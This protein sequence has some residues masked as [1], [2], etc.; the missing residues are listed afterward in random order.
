MHMSA[1]WG[2]TSK[3]WEQLYLKYHWQSNVGASK[4]VNT[5]LE[6]NGNGKWFSK[7]GTQVGSWGFLG[8][9]KSAVE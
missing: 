1:D 7:W 9:L 4:V 6:G 5:I 3:F 2:Q 8:Y